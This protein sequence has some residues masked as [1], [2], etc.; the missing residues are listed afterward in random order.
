MN[1]Q[2]INNSGKVFF[3]GCALLQDETPR[4][5]SWALQVSNPLRRCTYFLALY[6]TS[7][8]S[9]ADLVIYIGFVRV[10]KGRYLQTILLLISVKFFCRCMFFVPMSEMT[11]F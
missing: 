3:F 11:I 10:M 1:M 9:C 8:F 5:F 4:S 6:F 2:G 7:L